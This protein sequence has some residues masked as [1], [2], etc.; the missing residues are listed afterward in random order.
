MIMKPMYD[1]EV[2]PMDG[3]AYSIMGA[4]SKAIRRAGATD[5]QI[6]EYQ[7][8]S[9][10]GDYDNLIRVAMQYVNISI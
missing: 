3:N 9:R 4:V 7:E 6:K 10:S 1:I 8:K 2:T 5:E